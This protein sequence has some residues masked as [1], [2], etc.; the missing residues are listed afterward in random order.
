M[1][2]DPWLWSSVAGDG[3]ISFADARERVDDGSFAALVRRL[4]R[5]RSIRLHRCEISVATLNVLF[6]LGQ[7]MAEID[8]SY[9]TVPRRRFDW[10]T[11]QYAKRY[12]LKPIPASSALNMN[13]RLSPAGFLLTESLRE[14]EKQVRRGLPWTV[15]IRAVPRYCLI[16]QPI[17][18]PWIRIQTPLWP[19]HFVV[20]RYSSDFA[21]RER[22]ARNWNFKQTI[23]LPSPRTLVEPLLVSILHSQES[24][25]DA[26]LPAPQPMEGVD[27]ERSPR[28]PVPLR[29]ETP[30][31]HGAPP[32][33]LE[34]AYS[35]TGLFDMMQNESPPTQRRR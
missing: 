13:S 32:A 24:S 30:V 21:S 3:R 19:C 25:L 1:A 18:M 11:H 14:S 34:R 6:E 35:A 17:P 5:M 29:F 10:A 16:R 4:S 2:S 20:G 31:R 15:L 22:R 27:G 8:L 12:R 9:T 28:N 33:R 23:F 7:E 26:Q